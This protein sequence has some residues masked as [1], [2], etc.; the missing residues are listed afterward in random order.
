MVFPKNRISSN[1]IGQTITIEIVKRGT[2][3][4]TPVAAA[5][6]QKRVPSPE[7]RANCCRSKEALG[8]ISEGCEVNFRG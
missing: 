8:E 5:A 3:R 6:S 4:S 7:A 1:T 2:A